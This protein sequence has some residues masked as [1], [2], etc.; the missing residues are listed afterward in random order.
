[1][2]PTS[3][4]DRTRGDLIYAH[5][6]WR[7]YVA[8]FTGNPKKGELLDETA[9]EFF[10]LVQDM[11]IA[12]IVLS[13]TRLAD[14]HTSTLSFQYLLKQRRVSVAPTTFAQAAKA[15]KEFQVACRPH[16]NWRHNSIAHANFKVAMGLDHLGSLSGEQTVNALALAV[17]FMRLIDPEPGLNWNYDCEYPRVTRIL[18][19]AVLARRYRSEHRDLTSSLEECAAL[20]RLPEQE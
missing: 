2:P 7:T 15:L 9:P 5:Q 17:K 13:L 8:L 12:Q 6:L 14:T 19:E 20:H 10:V 4:F 16:L 1:M 3:S 18:L 11:L